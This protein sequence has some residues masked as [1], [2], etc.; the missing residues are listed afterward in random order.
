MLIR[1]VIAV[2]PSV[3]LV[4]E[5]LRVRCSTLAILPDLGPGA[6]LPK[7]DSSSIASPCVGVCK[8]EP[9]TGLCLGCLRSLEEIA[10]WSKASDAAK[11]TILE[12]IAER[13]GRE[14]ALPPPVA[15]AGGAR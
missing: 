7:V 12:R 14:D 9:S 13:Q 2:E 1:V 10:G 4:Y 8:I 15:R 5:E 6:A 11:R 3:K